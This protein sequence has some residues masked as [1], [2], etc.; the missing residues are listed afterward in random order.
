M[1]D[2]EHLIFSQWPTLWPDEI[3]YNLTKPQISKDIFCF[4]STE[5]RWSPSLLCAGSLGEHL[6]C[7]YASRGPGGTEGYLHL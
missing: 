4:L 2:R 7:V 3:A 1:G 6:I 5:H